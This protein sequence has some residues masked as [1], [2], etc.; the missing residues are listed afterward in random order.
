MACSPPNS[1]TTA[2]SSFTIMTP[3]VATNGVSRQDGFLSYA[4]PIPPVH[5]RL[6]LVGLA[7]GEALVFALGGPE[8]NRADEGPQQAGGRSEFLF[9]LPP[10]ITNSGGH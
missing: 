1:C 6:G 10:Q 2:R 7:A 3:I 4:D 9:D 5:K 8:Q